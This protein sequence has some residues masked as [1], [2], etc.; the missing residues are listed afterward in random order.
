MSVTVIDVD[1]RKVVA[2][3]PV[4]QVPKRIATLVMR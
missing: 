4:G 2:V 1:A 3:V